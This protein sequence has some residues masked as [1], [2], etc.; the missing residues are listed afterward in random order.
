MKNTSPDFFDNFSQLNIL[1]IGDV[2]LDRYWRGKVHRISP[3]APVPIVELEH[4]ENRLGGAANVALNIKYLSATPYLFSVIGNDFEAEAFTK[5][6]AD[7]N[8]YADGI[9][10]SSERKTTVKTRIV[11]GAQQLLR[12]DSEDTHDINPDIQ[13][14]FIQHLRTFLDK[15]T[16]HA[17]ILQDYNKGVLS[18][19]NIFDIL[20]EVHSRNIPIAVDPKKKNFF[21][22][23]NVALFK[24]NL[25]EI[26]EAFSFPI[27]TDKTSLQNAADRLRE[28]IGQRSTMITLSEKGIFCE[29]NLYNGFIEPAIPRS[30]T[31]V[32]GA[33]DT[34]ISVAAL[35]LA[36]KLNLKL[37]TLLANLAGGRV[38]ESSGVVPI[39][40][41]ELKKE[42]HLF[43]APLITKL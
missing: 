28:K 21:E 4:T 37:L 11:S 3:E 17:A 26:R 8:L 7:N 36:S 20:N 29:E 14:K 5:L 22:Y 32:S 18:S 24:P 6:L 34:V 42:F 39:S 38:C 2:M 31:D 19:K 16:I 9:L 1:I 13:E 30:I 35:C 15:T 33:G 27:T 12:L 23:K 40:L 10:Q 25:K 41:E 43:V